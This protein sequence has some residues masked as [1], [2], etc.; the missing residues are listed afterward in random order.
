MYSGYKLIVITAVIALKNDFDA[1]VTLAVVLTKWI[2]R[3][4]GINRI[5][6][7]AARGIIHF[8][9]SIIKHDGHIPLSGKR[10]QF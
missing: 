1:A 5:W 4:K 8:D 3:D 6:P 10:G 2:Q 7:L 9:G